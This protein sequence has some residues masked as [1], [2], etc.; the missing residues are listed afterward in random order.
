M[1][2]D[3]FARTP[4]CAGNRS[5]GKQEVGLDYEIAF[6]RRDQKVLKKY[7]T[8]NNYGRCHL[9]PPGLRIDQTYFHA[10]IDE[11][12]FP[13]ALKTDYIYFFLV[14]ISYLFSETWASGLSMFIVFYKS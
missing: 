14:A 11:S 13:D 10:D 5:R 8:G 4:A 3:D 2:E 9:I 6:L 1:I 12:L 7:L